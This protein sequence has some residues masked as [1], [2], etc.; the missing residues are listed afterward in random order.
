MLQTVIYPTYAGLSSSQKR[1]SSFSDVRQQ[2]R[3]KSSESDDDIII[4]DDL[5]EPHE[6]DQRASAISEPLQSF[7]LD[8]DDIVNF[9]RLSVSKLKSVSF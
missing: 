3:S 2:K 9:F 4:V 1:P 7:T 8:Q 5:D 6:N